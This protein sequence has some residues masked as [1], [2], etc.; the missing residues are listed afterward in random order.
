[1]NALEAEKVV[2]WGASAIKN[3]TLLPYCFSSSLCFPITGGDTSERMG[4]DAKEEKEK[5]KNRE[6]K[7]EDTEKKVKG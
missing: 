6:S 2:V 7:D 1:M 3:K 5:K 4:T